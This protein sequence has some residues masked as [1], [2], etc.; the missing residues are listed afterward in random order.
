LWV[1]GLSSLTRATDLKLI[2]S[3]YGKVIG[4][5]VVT[6]TRSPGQRCFGYVTMANAKDATECISNLHRTE[7]HG[8]TISVERAKSDIGPPKANGNSTASKAADSKGSSDKKS[9]NS[10]DSDRKD[11]RKPAPSDDKKKEDPKTSTSA[12]SSTTGKPERK[13]I[14]P[15]RSDSKEKVKPA[16]VAERFGATKGRPIPPQNIKRS[17]S[18]LVRKDIVPFDKIREERER[19]RLREKE[20]ELREEDRKRREIRRRQ[21]EEEQRLARE[22][23][24]LAL[25]RRRIEEQKAELLRIERERQKLEREKIELER[26]ELKRQ[27]RKYG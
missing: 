27:Q 9:V 10:R 1:S 4:A 16:P 14:S 12:T 13:R 7:L 26:L 6:N 3:K 11:I 18:P 2:F 19:Q 20:R 24:K 22:R 5:K 8:R 25:E 23:E 21:R 15:P 17:R